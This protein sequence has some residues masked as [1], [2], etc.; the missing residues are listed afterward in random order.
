MKN[1]VKILSL[2]LVCIVVFVLT[3]CGGSSPA[4]SKSSQ[5]AVKTFK[6]GHLNTVIRKINIK[7]WL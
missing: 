1:H 5:P 7:C 3:G 4:P 2:L 6:I